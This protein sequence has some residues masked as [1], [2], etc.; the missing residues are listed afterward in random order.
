MA[1]F[2]KFQSWVEYMAEGA[3]CGSDQFIIA[4]TA[5]ANAPVNTN[6]VLVDLTQISYTNCSTRS[7][8]TTSSSQTGGTYKLVVADLTL[9][10]SG[11]TVG[12]FQYV[13]MY[14]DT[15]SGKPLVGWWDNG[16]EITMAD[17]ATTFLDFS[18]ANG[19][20]QNT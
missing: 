10:A 7:L 12:P 18:A 2:N 20:I 17:T 9:T 14:D 19:V 4:L 13:V 5:A 3:N 15:V 1:S 16:S 6:S 11:G 8:T